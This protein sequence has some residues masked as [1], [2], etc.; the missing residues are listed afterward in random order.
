MQF[1]AYIS[2]LRF[3][4]NGTEIDL[5]S[6][7]RDNGDT[8]YVE[9]VVAR[10]EQSLVQFDMRNIGDSPPQSQDNLR[11]RIELEALITERGG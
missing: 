4:L 5:I 10:K 8:E 6:P 2:G 3:G 11:L 1:K 9:L 7:L